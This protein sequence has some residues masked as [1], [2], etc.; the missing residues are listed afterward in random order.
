M[1][2]IEAQLLQSLKEKPGGSR[3]LIVRVTG[4]VDARSD[5]LEKR[6]IKV[7]RRLS[8]TKSVAIRCS[9]EDALKLRRL[10]WV[11]RIEPDGIMRALGK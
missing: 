1:A 5:A 3:N 6:G 10:T 4:D 8:L 9:S 11:K 7:R 2:K